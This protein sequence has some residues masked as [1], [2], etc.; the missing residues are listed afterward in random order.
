[1][2]CHLEAEKGERNNILVRNNAA[3]AKNGNEARVDQ[4]LRSMG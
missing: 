2:E 1:M 4:M 3:S